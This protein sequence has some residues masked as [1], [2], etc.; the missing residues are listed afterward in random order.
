MNREIWRDYA[1]HAPTRWPYQEARGAG[2]MAL[3]GEK[4]GDVV[5][6]VRIPGFSME[7]CGGTHVRNTAE[8]GLFKIVAK[9]GVAAGVRR[10]EAVTGPARVPRDAEERKRAPRSVRAPAAF[11]PRRVHAVRDDRRSWRRRS[12]RGDASSGDAAATQVRSSRLV[13]AR[14]VDG[15]RVV[16]R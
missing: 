9:T 12:W 14:P 11:G 13:A 1:G 3:F 7:L 2:A 15:A 6:V 8:I 16:T 4:Y 5:R 10:I